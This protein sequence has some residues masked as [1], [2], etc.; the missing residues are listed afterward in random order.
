VAGQVAAIAAAIGTE[1]TELS[2]E[3][4]AKRE[5][6]IERAIE[7]LGDAAKAGFKDWKA[8]EADEDLAILRDRPGYKALLSKGP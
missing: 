3:Q 2:A 4:K 6:L 7:I 8:A 1:E 5:E